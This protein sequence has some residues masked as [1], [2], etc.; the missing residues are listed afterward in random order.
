MPDVLHKL[1]LNILICSLLSTYKYTHLF[2]CKHLS[3]TSRYLT[4]AFPNNFH[5]TH[6]L[7]LPHTPSSY[8]PPQVLM[9]LGG[10]FGER[11]SKPAWGMKTWVSTEVN[12]QLPEPA[13]KPDSEPG[14]QSWNQG[15]I[16]N[17]RAKGQARVRSQ[18]PGSG[19]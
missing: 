17:A 11:G 5:P 2:F 13:V 18:R 3:L 15:K 7:F 10:V 4:S 8:L 14:I 1:P 9:G 6:L 12:C 16:P 19:P